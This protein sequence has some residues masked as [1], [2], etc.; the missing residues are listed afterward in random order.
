[1]TDTILP[2]KTARFMCGGEFEAESF[3]TPDGWM[4]FELLLIKSLCE[5][6]LWN[7]SITAPDSDLSRL[8]FTLSL[9][10]EE[11]ESVFTLRSSEPQKNEINNLINIEFADIFD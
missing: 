9:P 1:M 4:Y 7:F 3:F 8:Q 10:E 5:Y 6:Y 2:E 11:E